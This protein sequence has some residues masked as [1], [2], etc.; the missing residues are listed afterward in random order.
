[1]D[2]SAQIMN[3]SLSYL[4]ISLLVTTVSLSIYIRVLQEANKKQVSSRIKNFLDE[5]PFENNPQKLADA[6]LS[7]V[8]K[9]YNFSVCSYLFINLN[10]PLFKNSINEAVPDLFLDDVKNKLLISIMECGVERKFENKKFNVINEG[11]LDNKQKNVLTDFIHVPILINDVLIGM[12]SFGSKNYLS[13]PEIQVIELFE[14]IRSKYEGLSR[15]E[16]ELKED[17]NNFEDLIN[18]MVSPVCMLGK[19]FELIYLNP[20]FETLFKLSSPKDFNI[21]DFVADVPGALDIER[22][23]QDVFLNNVAKNF[24]HINIFG[25]IYDVDIFPVVKNGKVEGASIL[26]Q[27]ASTDYKNE[28]IKQEFTAMLIHELRAPLTVIKS[29]SD[30][31]INRFS[32]LKESKIKEMLKGIISSAEG[33]LGLVS[34]LLDT[35]KIEMNKIQLMKEVVSFNKFI[36][37]KVTFFE[38]QINDKGLKLEKEFDKNVQEMSIDTGKFT[39]V[40]NNFMSNAI[41]YTKEGSIKISTKLEDGNIVLD[42]ADTGQ[43]IPDETKNKLFNKFVQ[44]ENSIKNKSKGTGLGLVVA[45]GIITAHKG[46]VKILDN[47]PAGTIFRIILPVV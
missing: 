45:K 10:E 9:K 39:S 26:F 18:S 46:D 17:K 20:S 28:Q 27:E 22:T 2:I 40:I 43:G 25:H 41:K 21:L 14:G 24:K 13:L 38:S 44:L 16:E 30:L 11:N 3:F 32:E 36:D 15:F 42:F 4:E 12:F 8:C 47:K 1:M 33:L 37:E 5:L 34:D 29:S 31:I 6:I 19:N 35:S 23:L 7:A